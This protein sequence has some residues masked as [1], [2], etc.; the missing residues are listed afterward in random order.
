MRATG[1]VTANT[2]LASDWNS[3]WV[4]TICL[5]SYFPALVVNLSRTLPYYYYF[6]A[7]KLPKENEVQVISGRFFFSKPVRGIPSEWGTCGEGERQKPYFREV[8]QEI[9][10][11]PRPAKAERC[12]GERG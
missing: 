7:G 8:S 6:L 11:F 4:C 3:K 1:C 9:H 10:L 12:D 2:P 5:L